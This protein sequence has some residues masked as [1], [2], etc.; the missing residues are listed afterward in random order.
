V[1]SSVITS[2]VIRFLIEYQFS[3]LMAR[4]I[5]FGQGSAWVS[6][7][8]WLEAGSSGGS[9]WGFCSRTMWPGPVPLPQSSKET[10]QAWNGTSAYGSSPGFV[11]S[12]RHC[13]NN[14]A[15]VGIKAEISS[16]KAVPQRRGS[17]CQA[18]SKFLH[19]HFSHQR[20]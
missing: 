9:P 18:S 10:G 16:F 11:V 15:Q 5:N 12:H 20:S 3:F 6:S 4:N 13:C 14:E 2:F 8:L 7:S 17:H 1:S 19:K